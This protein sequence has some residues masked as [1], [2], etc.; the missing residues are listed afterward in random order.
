MPG[1]RKVVNVGGCY[2]EEAGWLDDLDLI[3]SAVNA[4]LW[5]GD[6][7]Q[8]HDYAAPEKTV[9]RT[10]NI[11]T[12]AVI[13]NGRNYVFAFNDHRLDRRLESDFKKIGGKFKPVSLQDIPVRLRQTSERQLPEGI[14]QTWGFT[15]RNAEPFKRRSDLGLAL[16][17]K[18]KGNAW[19]ERKFESNIAEYEIFNPETALVQLL[20][21]LLNDLGVDKV[22]RIVALC[23]PNVAKEHA[24]MRLVQ[25]ALAHHWQARF[26]GVSKPCCERCA[27]AL[28]AA[29]FRYS[30][31]CQVNVPEDRFTLFSDITSTTV[32]VLH[33]PADGS[34]ASSSAPE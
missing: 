11:A 32:R 28:D 10:V 4:T 29:G 19:V 2:E 14:P 17:T 20:N 12:T 33:E 7:P 6:K 25:H 30:R 31:W 34:D 9:Q 18:I 21:D 5:S 26:I 27:D 1:G 13:Q 16:V 24:E 8:A 15:T 23:P 3:A 22:L